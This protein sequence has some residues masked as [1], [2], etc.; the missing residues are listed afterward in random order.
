MSSLKRFVSALVLMGLVAAT[1]AMVLAPEGQADPPPGPGT[2]TKVVR[3]SQSLGITYMP[4]ASG[5]KVTGAD[6]VVPFADGSYLEKGD[7]IL[8]VG[9]VSTKGTTINLEDKVKLAY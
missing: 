3:A 4:T 1:G 8:S 5:C 7:I 9:G 2:G 6:N